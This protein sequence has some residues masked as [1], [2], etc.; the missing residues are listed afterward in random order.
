[1]QLFIAWD[2][3]H[4][5]RQ[6]G[7]ASLADDA[8]GLRRISQAIDQG[9]LVWKSWVELSGGS[10]ISFGGD[11]GRAEVPADKLD[12]L[13]AIREQYSGK[14][15]S[16]VSVGVGLKLSEADK[17]LIAAKLRGGDAIVFYTDE[18]E[19]EIEEARRKNQRTEEQKITDEYL[20]KTEAVPQRVV[21]EYAPV[22][23]VMERFGLSKA[24]PAMN[25]GAFAG[26][27]RPSA[28]TVDKPVATQGD[29]E[30]GM[31][32]H[33]LLE[34]SANP[35]PPEQTHAAQDFERQLHEEAWKG[36]EEDMHA[37]VQS[38]QSLD[39]VKEQVYRALAALKMQGE[40]LEQVKQV[41]PDA[42]QA[43]VGLTQAVVTMARQL[44]A[45]PMRKA[46]LARKDRAAKLVGEV[47]A[48][49]QDELVKPEAQGSGHCLKGHCHAAAEALYHLL[50]GRAGGWAPH[51]LH[52]EGGPH[53]FVRHASGRVL[54]PVAGLFQAPP[55]YD[56]AQ[57][58]TFLTGEVPSG[59]A[60]AVIE[61]L[62]GKGVKPAEP[63]QKAEI[64]YEDLMKHA[65]VELEHYSVRPGLKKIGVN[66]MGTSGVPSQEYKQGVPDVPR[67]Y[68]YRAGS[69]PEPIVAQSAKA[70]YKTVLDPAK[71]KLYDVGLDP[72]NLRRPAHQ[73]F[74]DGKGL[75]T[76]E[77][78]F[79][80]EVKKR[81]YYGYLNS[82]SSMPHVV[83]LFH[84]HPVREVPI[85]SL[86]KAKLPMPETTHRHK[87]VLPVGSAA[88]QA[89]SG[90]VG[91]VAAANKVKVQHSDGGTAWKQVQAGM[92]RS[93]DPS[94]H[95]VSS[96]E[97]NSR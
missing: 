78:T 82:R 37:S 89:R 1:M 92:I 77:D 93:Q 96:R 50:G 22:G 49:L 73:K 69:E 39:Q 94:G 87:V 55:A 83:A 52:H 42:Y 66:K 24:A 58:A 90:A 65:P 4:I 35:A 91:T 79:L 57:P 17:A 84:A 41:A 67:A 88:G 3:D 12:E 71:H 7:R 16:P 27:S 95:P 15:G 10:L 46:E 28:P 64:R 31:V 23:E 68:Y 85:G 11:E 70:R 33:D 20:T 76:P 54:D 51:K 9:N 81:G 97:P 40:T 45:E 13:P 59:P 14:V 2:G 72:E 36:E 60:R 29:H 47:Q 80:A 26:A 34:S 62:L 63:A 56:Q 61:R 74:L 38:R 5:G 86:E 30:Q 53:W 32:M 19:Q 44:T 8:E 43:M 6:V 48:A 21:D 25:P 75:E 18:V